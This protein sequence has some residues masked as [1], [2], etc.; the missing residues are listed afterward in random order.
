MET[1]PDGLLWAA[2]AIDGHNGVSIVG[3]SSYRLSSLFVYF[4]NNTYGI[5]VASPT[6]IAQDNNHVWITL[7]FH[8]HGNGYPSDAAEEQSMVSRAQ[9]GEIGHVGA[10]RDTPVQHGFHD[11]GSERPK[12]E[13][14]SDA[15]DSSYSGRS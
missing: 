13:P 14:E 8:C 12:F 3:G 9:Y 7:P 4:S 10:P 6:Y 11:L 15:V 2:I 5:T 1:R